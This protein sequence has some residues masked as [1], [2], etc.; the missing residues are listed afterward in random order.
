[1]DIFTTVKITS[2]FETHL[3][4]IENNTTSLNID[5]ESFKNEQNSNLNLTEYNKIL[6]INKNESSNES[7]FNLQKTTEAVQSSNF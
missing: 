3:K 6:P 4:T 7:S 1:M 5:N 2:E